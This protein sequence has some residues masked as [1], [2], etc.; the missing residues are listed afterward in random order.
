MEILV[1]IY[2]T[3][4]RAASVAPLF[5]VPHRL[6]LFARSVTLPRIRFAVQAE[7]QLRAPP[8][9]I[10]FV[11]TRTHTPRRRRRTSL[12]GVATL[13]ADGS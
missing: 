12:T 2:L 4:R 7:V 11:R 5:A 6:H 1:A 10:P 9:R 3:S 13:V 8:F